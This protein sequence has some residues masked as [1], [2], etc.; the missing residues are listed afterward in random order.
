MY[1][2]IVSLLGQ[3]NHFS[4]KKTQFQQKNTIP[5]TEKHNSRNR[6]TQFRDRKT[7]FRDQLVHHG[8]QNVTDNFCQYCKKVLQINIKETALHC[9][10]ECSKSKGIY[11]KIISELE[12]E[13]IIAFPLTPKQVIIWDDGKNENSPLNLVNAIWTITINEILR[14]RPINEILKHEVIA[15]KIKGEIVSSVRAY[16]N[17]KIS[18]E[19]G[20]LGLMEFMASQ[21][22]NSITGKNRKN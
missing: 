8:C 7:Q 22:I 2:Q 5:G 4:N 6:K 3:E 13:N 17:K 1:F 9:L 14:A 18:S 21:K 20:R 12:L 15:K 10:W 16:P 11:E 19:I